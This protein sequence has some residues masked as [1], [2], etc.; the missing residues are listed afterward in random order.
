M[1]SR[2]DQAQ[3]FS[4][5]GAGNNGPVS[6]AMASSFLSTRCLEMPSSGTTRDSAF[7]APCP[8][9]NIPAW[10]PAVVM[11]TR[12]GVRPRLSTRPDARTRRFRGPRRDTEYVLRVR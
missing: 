4:F 11:G 5:T 12:R 3:L 7:R 1:F 6:T 10:S 9:R 2:E 8:V